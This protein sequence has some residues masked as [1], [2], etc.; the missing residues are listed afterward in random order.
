MYILRT[1]GELRP[2]TQNALCSTGVGNAPISKGL[3]LR[4]VVLT[5]GP[6]LGRS[7]PERSPGRSQH[8]FLALSHR[9]GCTVEAESACQVAL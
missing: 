4:T 5:P 9:L 2:P 7:G 1:L 6:G 3:E 8:S